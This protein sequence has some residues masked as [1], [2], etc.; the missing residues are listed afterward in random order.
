MPYIAPAYDFK[1]SHSP[2]F[3]TYLKRREFLASR[4]VDRAEIPTGFPLH[5]DSQ[6]VWSGSSL[7]IKKLTHSL[8]PLEIQEIE[9][10]LRFFK[11][12]SVPYTATFSNFQDYI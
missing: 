6:S 1:T 2:D 8:A 9:E 12:I 7:D 3:N 5:T 10:A 4:G 11:G